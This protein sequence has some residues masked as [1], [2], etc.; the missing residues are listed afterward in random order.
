[1]KRLILFSLKT[2]SVYH[3]L[4]ILPR[5]LSIDKGLIKL[6]LCNR[7]PHMVIRWPFNKM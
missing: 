5:V 2:I 1:M 6:D 7:K 4:K 3:L